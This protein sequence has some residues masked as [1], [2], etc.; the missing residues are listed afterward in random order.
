MNKVV[1]ALASTLA[2]P[3]FALAADLPAYSDA[4]NMYVS[5]HGGILMA[6]TIDTKIAPSAGD[7]ATLP[8]T[9][10]FDSGM[11]WGGA[12]GYSMNSNLAM[13]LEYSNA[14]FDAEDV[15]IEGT[16]YDAVGDASVQTIMGNFI[17]GADYGS[18]RPYIGAGLG[19]ARVAADINPDVTS[20]DL[21]DSD[22]A[23]AGQAF[24]GLNVAVTETVT[25]G[26]RYR[27]QMIGATDMT[28]DRG[29]PVAAESFDLQSVD[30]VLIVGF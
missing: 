20:D 7:D 25:I 27:Y 9:F 19:G 23:L 8:A 13:E 26:A 24:A 5:I 17:I 18:F 2:L 15:T 4:G 14:G 28:D 12:V 30:L 1:L 3:G 21:D 6:P 11:R 10:G 29:D 22:W 16:A